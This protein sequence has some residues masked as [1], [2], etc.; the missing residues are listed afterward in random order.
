M[1]IDPDALD[2]S[3]QRLDG[4]RRNDVELDTMLQ[5]VVTSA[6]SV[7]GVT[8]AGLL[9]IDPDEVLRYVAASDEAARQLELAQERTGEGPCVDTFVFDRVVASADLSADRRWP[10]TTPLVLPYGIRAVLGVPVRVGGVGVGSLNVYSDFPHVWDGTEVHA[11][12]AYSE[13][14]GNLL[15]TAL[16]A[17]QQNRL[18]EQLQHALDYRVLIERGV[19]FLMGRNGVDSVAA[20][21]DLRQRSRQSRRKVVDVAVELLGDGDPRPVG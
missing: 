19:G 21:R 17:R 11:L 12:E 1:W 18:A 20:F 6:V 4:L 7:F 10:A 16:A 8:G 3:L 9:L 14:V 2:A 15:L 13:L 5:A